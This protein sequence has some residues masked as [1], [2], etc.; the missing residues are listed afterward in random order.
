MKLTDEKI[1]W[2]TE[3]TKENFLPEESPEFF[4]SLGGFFNTYNFIC[5]N[6]QKKKWFLQYVTK[7]HKNIDVENFEGTAEVTFATAGACA[8]LFMLGLDYSSYL[9]K[10]L[11]NFVKTLQNRKKL[12]AKKTSANAQ[13][14]K[15]DGR[16]SFLLE[17]LEVEID[18][19]ITEGYK[20]TDFDMTNWLALNNPSPV[21]HSFIKAKFQKLLEEL[22]LVGID[23][24]VTEAYSHMKRLHVK[25]FIGLLEGMVTTKKIRKTR[26][27]KKNK[28]KKLKSPEKLV[29][30][31]KFAE[32]DEE[33]GISSLAPSKI[34]GSSSVLVWN[35]KYRTLGIYKALEGKELTVK[36]STILN[37]DEKTSFA[38]K[39]RK[40]KEVVP[41]VVT[42]GKVSLKNLLGSIKA[43][44]V[45]LKG[46]IGSE[47][48]ILRIF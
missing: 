43:K 34:V 47:I 32:K 1:Y 26:V 28:T 12:Y 6:E 39:I 44:P 2:G 21:Q 20:L 30:K 13:T 18:L 29:A 19:F 24:E 37:F 46:R 7:F 8:R 16:L 11:V 23:P 38:K 9:N 10:K 33:L 4:N 42:M 36:G 14:V 35:K 22:Q 40:P 15:I 48:V 3:P 45:V 5:S 17:S 25:R 31:V 41:E 27:V